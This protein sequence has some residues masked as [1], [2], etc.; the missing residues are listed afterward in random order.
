MG[1]W[2]AK[3]GLP[4]HAQEHDEH[5]IQIF[6]SSLAGTFL[7]MHLAAAALGLASQW[8][9]A[10]QFIE[11]ERVIKDVVGIPEGLK[12][13]DMM[14]VGYGA[15]TPMPKLVRDREDIVH[16]DDCGTGDFRTEEEVVDYAR[17][18]KSWCI[19]ALLQEPD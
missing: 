16:Y 3:V 11:P 13:Y 2:R 12:V 17:R 4:I 18:T 15:Y 6:Y 7:Y 19:A 1:D 5:V 14:V 8:C 9:S 10:S